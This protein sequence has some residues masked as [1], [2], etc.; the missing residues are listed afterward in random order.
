M[1]L[2]ST[3]ILHGHACGCR[4]AGKNVS[5]NACLRVCV[6]WSLRYV[7]GHAYKRCVRTYIH[8][9]CARAWMCARACVGCVR[10]HVYD[11]V[12]THTAPQ[13]SFTT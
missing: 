12:Y 10:G 7:N 4:Y 11:V 5:L 3:C 9:M 6:C 13:T 1:K 8:I 2:I